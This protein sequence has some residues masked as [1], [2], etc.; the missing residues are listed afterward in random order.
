MTLQRPLLLEDRVPA[1]ESPC[2]LDRAIS[3][4]QTNNNDAT[5]RARKGRTDLRRKRKTALNKSSLTESRQDCGEALQRRSLRS[6]SKE[7]VAKAAPLR[8]SREAFLPDTLSA[9]ASGVSVGLAFSG[10]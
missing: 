7:P 5:A 8:R 6:A 9:Q 10:K 1:E 4:E 3:S 2:F